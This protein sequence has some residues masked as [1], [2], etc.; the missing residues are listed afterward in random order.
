MYENHGLYIDGQWCE[1]SDGATSAVINP[2][3]G[4]HLGDIPQASEKDL[5]RVTEAL[6]RGFRHWRSVSG[7]ERA[8]LLRRM[9]EEIRL[10]SEAGA[11]QMTMET[12]KPLA[13]SRAEYVAM[14]EQ[15]DWY[16]GEACRIFGHSL[17]GRDPHSRLQV[18]FDPV[19]PVAAFTAWNFPGLLPARKLAPALA[20]GC[21]IVIKPSEEAP[22]ATY[23]L[24]EAASA[25][26]LPGDVLSVVTGNSRMISTCLLASPVIRKL[27]FTGSVPVGKELMRQCVEGMKRISMELGGHAPVLVLE[28]ADP[29]AVGELCARTKFRNAGQVCISPS[30]FHVHESIREPFEQAMIEVANSLTLGS[31]LDEAT[32]FGPMANERGQMRALSL[33]NDA[34]EKGAIVGAGGRVPEGFHGGF[35]VEPTVLCN[36][37]DHADILT[38]EPFA[39]V[40]PICSFETLDEAIERANSVPF[41]LAAYVFT[42]SMSHAVRASEALESGMVGVNDMLLAAAEAPFGGVKESGFGREGGQLGIRDYLEPKYIKFRLN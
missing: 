25:A 11:R 6:S 18:R 12:G 22:S 31:G 41:G 3:D 8:A 7:W 9:A 26:G 20:A 16:A 14:A 4:S 1:A 19:G 24:A 29:V 38:T 5:R 30:R 15:F 13:E 28:D 33:I 42:H 39:P 32:D 17:D 2:F 23:M 36:V 21:S 27:S 10:R 40:A 35:F 34:R 37:P